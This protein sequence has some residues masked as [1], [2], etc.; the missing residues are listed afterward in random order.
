MTSLQTNILKL[1][2]GFGA[3][4]IWL[5]LDLT[6]T[7]DPVL[8]SYLSSVFALLLGHQLGAGSFRLVS[9]PTPQPSE[10]PE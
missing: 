10:K 6:K 3:A 4:A 5:T 7:S 1:L 9:Q 8:Q 2:A